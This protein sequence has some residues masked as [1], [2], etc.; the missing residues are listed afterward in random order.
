LDSSPL[1]REETP[2]P[3]PQVPCSFSNSVT[4]HFSNMLSDWLARSGR[5]SESTGDGSEVSSQLGPVLPLET[6]P[7]RPGSFS[8]WL[9]RR[10]EITAR[11]ST[12]RTEIA[13]GI[14]NFVANSYLVVL[15]P[16]VLHNGGNGLPQ[17]AYLLSFVLS[18]CT[19]SIL[20]GWFSNLPLPCGGGIGCAT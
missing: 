15:I 5:H 14:V 9:D 11:G 10:F 6:S 18:T 7:Y 2:T 19:S 4:H 16:Q 12:I 3:T 17:Q 13:A 20:V 8:A 1:R